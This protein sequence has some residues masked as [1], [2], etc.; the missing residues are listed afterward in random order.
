MDRSNQEQVATEIIQGQLAT[1]FP[2][3]PVATVVTATERIPGAAFRA[4]VA[5]FVEQN[6]GLSREALAR[7]LRD[8][9]AARG[10]DYHLRTLKRQI[11]GAV[12][13]VPP[14]VLS[15]VRA[16]ISESSAN[17]AATNAENQGDLGELGM[18]DADA[19]PIYLA[20]ERVLPFAELW[21]YLHPDQSK[22]ALAMRLRSELE[23]LGIRLNIDS[24]QSILAGKQQLVRREVKDALLAMLQENGIENAT[25]AEARW[26]EMFQE[27][28]AAHEGRFFENA[29]KIHE[30]AS[31]WKI[32]HKEP[33]SRKLALNLRQRL[34][35]RGIE[36]GLPH[37]QKLVDGRA[38][39]VRHTV[40]AAIED[41]LREEMA[42]QSG[43]A[44][45]SAAHVANEDD[46]AWVQAEPIAQMALQYV[47][48]NPRMTMRKLSMQISRVVERY[49]YATSP[50]TIQPI[51]GGHKKKT[52]G[53]I[54]RAMLELNGQQVHSIP[55]AHVMGHA[56]RRGRE[57]RT[58]PSG[59]SEAS[60]ASEPS[61]SSDPQPQQ[62]LPRQTP[63]P[64]AIANDT[65][66]PT[67]AARSTL[68]AYRSAIARYRSLDRATE[69]ELA[70]R[71]RRDGDQAAA[72]A[73][74]ESHL[75]FVVKV[76]AQY[77]GYGMQLADLVEEGNLGL[78]EAVRRFEPARNLRFKTYAIYWIRAFVVEH[79][80]R[81]WS[82]VGGGTGA[83]VSRTFFR[84][85]RERARLE[86]QLGEHDE[87]IDATLARRFHTSE[88]TIRAMT[89]RVGSR[90][91]SLDAPSAGDGPSM[92]EM[93]SDP[94]SDPEAEVAAAQ[95]NALVRGVV[96]DALASF[97]ARERLIVK[98]RLFVDDD[99][100]SL[101]DLGRRLGVS[102]ERVRQLEER[103]KSK[104]RN[105]FAAAASS[106]F[107]FDDE[108]LCA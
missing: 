86:S 69:L 97:D 20:R 53:F 78:L 61:A 60:E 82:I 47:A 75:Q 52:R 40:A 5:R 50:N 77:R 17:G 96:N 107:D 106:S 45:V 72:Q 24:L 39:R 54:Y 93:L 36:M 57:H 67:S 79:L 41:I 85:R 95:R 74:V 88:E 80:L 34:A 91:T 13:T 56:A 16:I 73:L 35:E 2:Q 8:R 27:I 42:A 62:E 12:A 25:Q 71:Y 7:D 63:L 43:R 3:G 58:Q 19:L 29:H 104:L 1:A 76:V 84:L 89:Q 81:E 10:I 23:R 14:E 100:L 44:T 46:L 37:I 102:R 59:A 98:T 90:D 22:R 66:G 94:L 101:A 11:S 26:Q 32:V 92:L 55:L 99:E 70:W 108:A 9:L 31:E 51:L 6:P 33:S 18:D 68:A 28:R 65:A 103:T 48:D 38:Q 83:L 4:M 15:T 64:R 21:L 105:A 87:S 30:V 49:G